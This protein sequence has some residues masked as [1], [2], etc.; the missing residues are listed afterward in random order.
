MKTGLLKPLTFFGALFLL[1]A[2]GPQTV[3]ESML[4][5]AQNTDYAIK[6][7]TLHEGSAYSAVLVNTS[8]PLLSSQT[9]ISKYAGRAIAG[10]PKEVPAQNLL[11]PYAE[12]TAYSY[13]YFNGPNCWHTSIASIFKEWTQRRHMAEGEFSCLIRNYFV[14]VK[15]PMFGDVVRFRG[16]NN[17]EIHSATFIGIDQISKEA[18]VYTKNGYSKSEPWTF[19]SLADVKRVYPE[20]INVLFFAPLRKA[21]EPRNDAEPCYNEYLISQKDQDEYN[22]GEGD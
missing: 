21:L 9:N 4:S 8:E 15:S 18:I 17:K 19:M 2:C 20:A 1:V 10:L 12:K 11:S 14:E 16:F 3:T 7:I 13:S 6:V 5:G 22:R